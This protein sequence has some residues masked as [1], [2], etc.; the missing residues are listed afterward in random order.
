MSLKEAE[1][2]FQGVL[3]SIVLSGLVYFICE[4]YIDDLIIYA[5]TETEFVTRLEQVLERLDKH[6]VTVHPD[7]CE[8]G[9]SEVEYY[10]PTWV[11]FFTR[12]DRQSLRL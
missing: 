9:I 1:A 3:A 11:I 5:T 6:N 7:K 2:Y 12:K 8:L 10:K 4:L